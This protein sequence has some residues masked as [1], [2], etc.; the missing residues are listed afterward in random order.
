MARCGG[1]YRNFHNGR[2]QR[3]GA[4]AGPVHLQMVP[5]RDVQPDRAVNARAG[6]PAAVGLIRIARDDF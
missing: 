5:G 4:D 1:F 6:V 2:V 3:K